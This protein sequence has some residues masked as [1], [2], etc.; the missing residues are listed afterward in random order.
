LFYI[1]SDKC[2]WFENIDKLHRLDYHGLISGSTVV[3]ASNVKA[4][5]DMHIL[6]P[7]LIVEDI[8]RVKDKFEEDR[9]MEKID[10]ATEFPLKKYKFVNISAFKEGTVNRLE[11]DFEANPINDCINKLKIIYGEILS[12][13]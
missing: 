10:C 11:D 8:T 13:G 6:E 12:N 5:D 1:D 3:V 9:I 4:E 7:D 2:F